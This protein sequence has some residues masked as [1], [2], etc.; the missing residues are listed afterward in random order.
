MCQ[1][2]TKQFRDICV[3]DN[4]GYDPF[5][6]V[7]IP[8]FFSLLCVFLFSVMRYYWIYIMSDTTDA[9][10]GAGTAYSSG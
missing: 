5:V 9:P 6:V 2:T 8:S 7:R 4:D 10:R 1:I 3:T